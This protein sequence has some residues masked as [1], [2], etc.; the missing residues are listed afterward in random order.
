MW[1]IGT[2]VH[3]A[4]NP[5]NVQYANK[6]THGEESAIHPLLYTWAHR[7]RWS[8]IV[9][10]TDWER[11]HTSP[12]SWS[13]IR[14]AMGSSGFELAIGWTLY[15]CATREPNNCFL[16]D[17]FSVKIFVYDACIKETCKTL[18]YQA[19]FWNWC[20]KS[21]R[22]YGNVLL[23]Y[24]HYPFEQHNVLLQLLYSYLQLEFSELHKKQDISA[25]FSNH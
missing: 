17:V 23:V 2:S 15:C 16:H 1:L 22:L 18:F 21:Y 9:A 20:C 6:R 24:N 3:N 11:E 5:H 12:P 25:V 7:R 19:T 4:T 13:Q 10:V 14:M 8:A